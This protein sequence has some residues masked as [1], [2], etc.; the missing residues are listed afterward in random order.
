[1]F[2]P[3]SPVEAALPILYFNIFNYKS[4]LEEEL[5]KTKEIAINVE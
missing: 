5:I 3:W 4:F 1:M 2:F